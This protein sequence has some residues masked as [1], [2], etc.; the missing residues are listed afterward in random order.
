[1]FKKGKSILL[2]VMTCLKCDL[3]ELL[4]AKHQILHLNLFNFKIVI[5]K[6]FHLNMKEYESQELTSRID[7][8]KRYQGSI[9]IIQEYETILQRQKRNTLIIAYRQGPIFEKSRDSNDF[10]AKVQKNRND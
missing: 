7:N 4:I 6:C 2:L 8:A 9:S 10:L 3:R 5:V 1:M